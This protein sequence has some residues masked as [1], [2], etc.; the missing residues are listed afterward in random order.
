LK[1]PPEDPRARDTEIMTEKMDHLNKIV[2][3]L[4]GYARSTEPTLELV[5]VND[6]LD[7]VLLLTRQKLR[8]QGI[9]LVRK[10]G[11]GLPKLRADR[12]QIEQACLNLILNAAD[13][14]VRGG[15]LTVTSA[16]QDE[17]ESGLVLSFADTGTG[18]APEKQKRLF[19]PFLT[20]KSHGTGL[21]LAIV[22]KIV[23][24]HRGKIE[25]K[26]APKKGTTF[27]I[28]LPV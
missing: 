22:Q 9:E 14:M 15:T 24:A 11:E 4:L 3:H 10:F 25:V 20:T 26:S 19:E 8:Q 21:G 6:L 18:M 28:L 2:D 1:F 7:D 12:G 16:R 17:P 5:D 13:A 27:R 23:E